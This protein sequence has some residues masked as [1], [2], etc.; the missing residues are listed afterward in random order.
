[1]RPRVRISG[2]ST[3]VVDADDRDWVFVRV[4][5][6]EPG[7]VGWGESSLGW[8]TFRQYIDKRACAIIQPN[9]C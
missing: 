9:V 6:D 8:H 5:T 7:L 4:Q 3:I 2:V 1:M